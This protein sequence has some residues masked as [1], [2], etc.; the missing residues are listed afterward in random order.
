MFTYIDTRS[1]YAML[2]TQEHTMLTR[3]TSQKS[4]SLPLV[5][6]LSAEIKGMYYHAQQYIS[7]FIDF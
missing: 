6:K 5:L 1:H 4:T 7:I 2:A 3:L